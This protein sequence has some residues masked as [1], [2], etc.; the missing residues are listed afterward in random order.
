MTD[1]S[2]EGDMAV[3][4]TQDTEQAVEADDTDVELHAATDGA[5]D[6]EDVEAHTWRAQS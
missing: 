2:E 3:E 5:D 4:D 6:D 1:E